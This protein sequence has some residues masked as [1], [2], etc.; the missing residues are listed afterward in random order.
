MVDAFQSIFKN[1]ETCDLRGL[2][3][4]AGSSQ[5]KYD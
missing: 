2:I 4:V 3:Q 1:K 5:R